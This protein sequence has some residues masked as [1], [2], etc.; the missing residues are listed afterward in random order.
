ML[1]HCKATQMRKI[2]GSIF[3]RYAFR[4][5]QDGDLVY[6]GDQ[7]ALWTKITS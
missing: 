2:K 6:Q 5:E 1:L 4:F 7:S 3:A